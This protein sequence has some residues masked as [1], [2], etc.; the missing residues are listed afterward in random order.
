MDGSPPSLYSSTSRD[1]ILAA[2]LDLSQTNA[3]R[4]IPV[5]PDISLSGD[6]IYGSRHSVGSSLPVTHVAELETLY[7]KVLADL[8]KTVHPAIYLSGTLP[9]EFR[10]FD[11]PVEANESSICSSDNDEGSSGAP[12]VQRAVPNKSSAAY[13]CISVSQNLCVEPR[14]CGKE[15]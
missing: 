3:G 8:G 14:R 6:T 11:P 12:D 5:I 10:G 7:L 2:I 1:A 15:Q 9:T 13:A 4:P